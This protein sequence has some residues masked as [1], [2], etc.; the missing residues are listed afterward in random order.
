MIF[1]ADAW[2]AAT[3]PA[4]TGGLR[5]C[6]A[7]YRFAPMLAAGGIAGL[8]QAKRFART[9]VPQAVALMVPDLGTN[10]MRAAGVLDAAL[11]NLAV[12]AARPRVQ[13]V[14][15]AAISRRPYRGH[16]GGRPWGRNVGCKASGRPSAARAR[17]SQTRWGLR[18]GH[19]TTD[20]ML[21][22]LCAAAVLLVFGCR[23]GHDHGG[24]ESSPVP[25]SAPGTGG[26]CRPGGCQQVN[27]AA[28]RVEWEGMS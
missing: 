16:Q 23:I 19:D 24:R 7:R 15:M 27:G 17:A 22:H 28:E 20:R 13:V 10:S 12:E 21:P 4:I 25:C 26:D 14:A 9:A 1:T 6:T 11:C 8:D 18:R 2:I 3:S 5:T